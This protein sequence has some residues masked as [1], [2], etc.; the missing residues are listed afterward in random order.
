MRFL[1]IIAIQFISLWTFS[2]SKGIRCIYSSSM[3]VSKG[4][5]EMENE[6]AKRWLYAIF[7]KT[8]RYIR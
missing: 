2:Q 5:Y 1:T 4:V 3:E 7:R 8:K 6:I